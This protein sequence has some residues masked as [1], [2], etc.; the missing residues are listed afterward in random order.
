MDERTEVR[1]AGSR[2]WPD[3]S[4][5][6]VVDGGIRPACAVTGRG[7]SFELQI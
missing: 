3:V 4:D 6:A 1:T 7:V 5:P 2:S